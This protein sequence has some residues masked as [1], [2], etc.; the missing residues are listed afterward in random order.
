MAV[1][2]YDIAN[3]LEGELRKTDEFLALESAYTELK[4]NQKAYDLFKNFQQI[5]MKLQQKQMQGENLEDSEIDEAKKL[6]DKVGKFKE[7]QTLMEKEKGLSQIMEDLNGII[8]KPVQE[9]Y[10]N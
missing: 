5:N 4:K 6:A 2:V 10:A 7:I 3:Q 9:L 1:K 8:T